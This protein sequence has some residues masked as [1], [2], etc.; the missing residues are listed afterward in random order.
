MTTDNLLDFAAQLNQGPAEPPQ[1][2]EREL[3]LVVFRLNREEYAVP[4]GLVREVVRVADMTRVPHAPAHIRGVMNLRGR[5]LPVVEIR[6][7]LG[8]APAEVTS[9]SRVVVAEVAGRTVGLLVDEV[10]QVTRIGERLVAAA[11]EEVRSAGSEAVTG[12]AR[13]GTRLLILLDLEG[14][15]VS[16]SAA[17]TTAA[18]AASAPSAPPAASPRNRRR[19]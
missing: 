8:L 9:A 13:V 7:R 11:P 16:V 5:I 18:S 19:P 4:I 2:E 10:G 12:V 14:V 6:S 15:L 3:H 1:A 17:T